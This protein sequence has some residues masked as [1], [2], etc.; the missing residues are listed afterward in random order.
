MANPKGAIG[1]YVDIVGSHTIFGKYIDCVF[2]VK[3][4]AIKLNA[5]ETV[6]KYE[7]VAEYQGFEKAF[8]QSVPAVIA[9]LDVDCETVG[10]FVTG[11]SDEVVV[12]HFEHTDRLTYGGGDGVALPGLVDV[13]PGAG[14]GGV[15]KAVACTRKDETVVEGYIVDNVGFAVC[16]EIVSLGYFVSVDVN[17]DD[18][19]PSGEICLGIVETDVVDFLVATDIAITDVCDMVYLVLDNEIQSGIDIGNGEAGSSSVVGDGAYTH[20]GETFDLCEGVRRTVAPVVVEQR[21]TG[22]S[23]DPRRGDTDFAGT[24]E[25]VVVSPLAYCRLSNRHGTGSQGKNQGE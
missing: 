16:A 15:H 1:I 10:V 3:I 18:T 7:S 20:I 8:A 5:V 12:V 6:D 23:V 24:D 14:L 22:G 4:S 9:D 21:H 17:H 13:Q 19:K 25:R 2:G 11:S